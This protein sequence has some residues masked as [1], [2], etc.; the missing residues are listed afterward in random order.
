MMT[1]GKVRLYKRGK[2]WYVSYR[3]PRTGRRVWK[4]LGTDSKSLAN[5]AAAK[6]K[7]EMV[8]RG[9]FDD[10][11]APTITL[12]EFAVE[13]LAWAR[14]EKTSVDNDARFV[15]RFVS[16]WGGKLLTEI[17]PQM[18]ER[19]K[20][21]RVQEPLWGKDANRHVSKNTVNHELSVLREIFSKA[22][23]WGKS[24]ADPM[25][26]VEF[27]KVDDKRDVFLDEQQIERLLA[28]CINP[29]APHIH[30][31]TLFALHTGMRRGEILRLKWDDIDYRAGA[32]RVI[33][34][35]GSET[36]SRRQRFV[37]LFEGAK[38]ALREVMTIERMAGNSSP[39]V[40][41]SDDGQPFKETKT[42]F[43]RA[44]RLAGLTWFRFHDTRHCFAREYL[45]CGGTLAEL[46]E[47]LG[48]R[49]YE[50]TLRYARFAHGD[51]IQSARRVG[52]LYSTT[53]NRGEVGTKETNPTEMKRE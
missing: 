15:Q 50:Q 29:Q 25:K 23:K 18:I 11:R 14:V 31:M 45:L 8:E 36:K 38:E 46:R 51:V 39:W 52:K 28:A 9:F 44:R 53:N 49:T 4:S 19:W 47:I 34:M 3:D 35:E 24:D 26:N 7:V 37:P 41:C 32:I 48:H 13:Y 42:G 27:Y 5:S 17:T 22:R 1:S 20:A 33:S 43:N 12:S 2:S 40:F 21:Q 30:A 10:R 6:I 16:E